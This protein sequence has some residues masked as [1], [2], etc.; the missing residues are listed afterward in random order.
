[1]LDPTRIVLRIAQHNPTL[2][3]ATALLS[4]E[5][6]RLFKGRKLRIDVAERRSLLVSKC[7]IM[8]ARSR[9]QSFS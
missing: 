7:V 9:F 3:S 8:R 4:Q 5:G 1:V 2:G 6:P